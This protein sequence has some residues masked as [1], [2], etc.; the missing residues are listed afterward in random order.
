VSRAGLEG[1]GRIDA[2][3]RLRLDAE[4]IATAWHRAST[5]GLAWE[6]LTRENGENEIADTGTSADALP[7]ATRAAGAAVTGATSSAVEL[8]ER[9]LARGIL[10]EHGSI[11]VTL[12]MAALLWSDRL[13]AA[14]RICEEQIAAGQKQGSPRLVAHF[15]CFRGAIAYRRGAVPDAEAD[16]RFAYELVRE[17]GT[18]EGLPWPLAYLVD[19]LIERGDCDAAEHALAD[20][21]LVEPLQDDF[22]ATLLI[23]RRGRLRCAEGHIEAGLADLRDAGARAAAH[24]CTN[25]NIATWR[26]EAALALLQLGERREARQLADEQ[27]ELARKTEIPA[28]VG[29]ALRVRGIVTAEL[30]DLEEAVTMLER[31]EARL[32]LAR[33]LLDL[34]AALRRKG[35]RAVAREHLRRSLDLAHRCGAHAL[36]QRAHEELRAAG[37]RPR[38]PALTGIDALTASERRVAR[39]AAEGLA[40]REIAQRLFVTQ[41]TVETHLMHVFQKLGIRTRAALAP[42]LF[43]NA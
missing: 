8:A 37:G 20:S 12:T 2:P 7:L 6:R 4:L 19:S 16:T 29:I 24:R 39:L 36:V 9:A 14:G 17:A 22:G 38:R 5:A 25:P 23:E 43:G 13:A 42:E 31:T 1:G 15:T 11:L 41:R 18:L 28:A 33:A 21:G 27:L 35:E 10:S 40:N 32:E 30:A 26:L 3:T 34:G